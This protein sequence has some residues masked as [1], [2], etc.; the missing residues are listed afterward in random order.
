M[1]A[2]YRGILALIQS[3]LTGQAQPLPEDFDL[4]Q[5]GG[6]VLKHSLGPI[7]Y[8]GATVCGYRRDSR[9]MDR[10]QVEYFR[11]VVISSRQL[12]ALEEIFQAFRDHGIDFLT[13]KGCD[14]KKLYPDPA[15]RSMG[16]ADVL[17]RVAQYGKIKPLMEGLGYALTDESHYDYSWQK[18]ELY[19]ELHKRLFAETQVDLSGY[20]GT[21]WDRA[22]PGEGHRWRLSLE[23][24]YAYI[25]AHMAK[26]FRIQGIGVRQLLDIHVF[27]QAH[28]ELDRARVEQIMA[29]LRLGQFHQNVL[30]M[31]DMWFC[32]GQADET[33]EL[34]TEYIFASGNWG[35]M[36][37]K[38]YAEELQKAQRQGGVKNSRL[39]GLLA[40]VFPSL[41]MLQ[42]RYRV[43]YRWPVLYPVFIV[44]RWVDA[45]INRRDKIGQ[46][47]KAIQEMSDDRV[48]DHERSMAQ[49]GLSFDY[50]S[51]V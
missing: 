7:I 11:S 1:K 14:L 45:L 44:V 27:R 15:L 40:A 17:I 37:R 13:V 22:L 12:Q 21:G 49:M 8:R 46:K 5:V 16:D 2:E 28:P 6:L 48:L 18:P 29:E 34:M 23:D 33:T 20:F 39:K 31:L 50:G 19:I 38:M 43:L 26:H 4:E 25:F 42:L 32:G 24:E 3:A 51:E 9:A 10:L 41:G 30:R 35:N 36:E 47:A